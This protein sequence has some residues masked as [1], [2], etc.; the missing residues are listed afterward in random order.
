VQQVEGAETAT[1]SP[2]TDGAAA[3]QTAD[4]TPAAEGAEPKPRR[5]RRRKPAG[6]DAVPATGDDATPAAGEP[7]PP[8]AAEAGAA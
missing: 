8:A 5:R 7:E 2:E 4:A 1:E 3:E 6:A